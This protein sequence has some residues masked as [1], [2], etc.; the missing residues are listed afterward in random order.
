MPPACVHACPSANSAT[1]RGIPLVPRLL[2]CTAMQSSGAEATGYARLLLSRARANL[3]LGNET[4]ART[5][6]AELIQVEPGCAEAFKLFGELAARHDSRRSAEIFYREA[7]RL[8]PGDRDAAAAVRHLRR[9]RHLAAGTGTSGVFG[10]YTVFEKL[11]EGGMATVHRAELR[12]ADGTR[13]PCALKRLFPIYAADP[14]VVR[15][16]QHEAQLAG[17]LHHDHIVRIFDVGRVHDVDYIAM[18]LIEGPSLSRVLERCADLG[19]TMPIPYVLE[20]LIQLCSALEMAHPLGIV[21]RDM[22]PSNVIV[23]RRGVKLIDFGIAKALADSTHTQAGVIKGKPGYIAPEYIHGQLDARA[24]LFGLGVIAH[25]MLTGRR[26]FRGDTTM[27]TLQRVLR[28]EVRPPSTRNSRVDAILDDIVMLAL[29]RDP[30]QRWQSARAM[31]AALSNAAY[32]LELTLPDGPMSEW[33]QRMGRARD[34]R[35]ETTLV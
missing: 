15:S 18:E 9:R 19:I 35:A 8:A 32:E 7:L 3:A 17:S 25:E 16:F 23:S 28:M 20:V 6:L 33:V 30:E 27:D 2:E 14:D 34:G 12:H 13:T 31:R 4:R 11:G 29:R 1:T 5:D 10:P 24:D 26:L 22:S 21:H